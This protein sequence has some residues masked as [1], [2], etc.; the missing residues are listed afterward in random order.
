MEGHDN[1]YADTS[2]DQSRPRSR[3]PPAQTR[4]DNGT[5]STGVQHGSTRCVPRTP[6]P[7]SYSGSPYGVSAQII[8]THIVVNGFCS[9]NFVDIGG[10]SL[11]GVDSFARWSEGGDGLGLPVE[12]R[13]SK[14]ANPPK[15][16]LLPVPKSTTRSESTKCGKEGRWRGFCGTLKMM[17]SSPSMGKKMG[18]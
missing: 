16:G 8:G 13:Q 4:R 10:H 15:G 9:F 12:L 7:V 17:I 14:V 11:V 1:C 3:G 2:H 6:H 18:S 5:T